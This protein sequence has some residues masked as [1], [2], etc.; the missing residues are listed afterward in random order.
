MPPDNSALKLHEAPVTASPGQSA[1]DRAAPPAAGIQ[2]LLLAA[3]QAA[4]LC[5]VSEAT[6]HRMN[7]AGRCPAPLRLSRGCVR[8][9]AEELR[10]WVQA[11]TPRRKE[12]EAMRGGR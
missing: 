2:P 11:G 6:W 12:W 5:G 1:A 8:W 4:A 10:A 3:P 9:R 7:A